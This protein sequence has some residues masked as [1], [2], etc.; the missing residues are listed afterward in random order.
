MTIAPACYFRRMQ[1]FALF[2]LSAAA[3]F[4]PGA[5]E[6][7]AFTYVMKLHW[8]LWL[9]AAICAA[10]QCL[11]YVVMY[12]FGEWIALRWR[13][14]ARQVAA[15]RT[16]FAYHLERRFLAL[17]VPS[18]AVGIPPAIAMSVLGA[19]FGVPLGHLIPALYP[20]RVLRFA[21][22]I[23]FG[24]SLGGWVRHLM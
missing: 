4:V 17:C 10:G 6:G 1:L 19:P 23:A 12:L 2:F 3:T 11:A 14:L 20:G 21:A 22:I 15:V 13:G 5:P 8:N 24:D 7:L 16:R 18:S 9:V